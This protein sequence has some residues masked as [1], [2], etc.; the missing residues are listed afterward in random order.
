MSEEYYRR[1]VQLILR[2]RKELLYDA[3]N[4]CDYNPYYRRKQF[5]WI[6]WFSTMILM[7]VAVYGI[8][9]IIS[10]IVS[11][12]RAQKELPSIRRGI[13]ISPVDKLDILR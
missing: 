5:P 12:G 7:V 10:S 11:S 13:E 4:A 1:K 3:L 8:V 9:I 2:D 6:R